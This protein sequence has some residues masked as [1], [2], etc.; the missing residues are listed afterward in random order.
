MPIVLFALAFI[1]WAALHSMTAGLAFKQAMRRLMGERA[2][3]GLY[4]LL[5][6]AFSVLTFIPVLY[7]GGR[8][9]PQVFAWVVD[10]PGRWFLYGL[11]AIGL[12]GVG[13][14]LLQTDLLRFAG[15]GQA[16]RYLRG[17]P[18]VNPPPRLV[19]RGLY[20]LVRHP[21]YFFSLI[22]L[23]ANPVMSLAALVF[24]LA[25]TAYFWIGS[26]YEERRL[27]ATYGEAYQQYRRRVPRLIPL[28]PR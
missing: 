14:S 17:A 2:Y 13:V 19:V 28:K 25:A 22:F 6:N 7:A 9:L 8:I 11:Q 21:I 18:E 15:L 26:G 12:I 23:W 27:L 3:D 1:F 5:Y 16:V 24:N 4:R 10:R 20:R